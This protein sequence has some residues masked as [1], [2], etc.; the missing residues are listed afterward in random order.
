MNSDP[1]YNLDKLLEQL[2]NSNLSG[3]CIQ[4]GITKFDKIRRK[5]SRQII[6]AFCA[7]NLIVGA[8]P[9]GDMIGVPLI[10]RFMVQVLACFSSSSTR[11][12]AGFQAA[13]AAVLLLVGVGRIAGFVAALMTEFASLGIL[14][15]VGLAIGAAT[16]S[17]TTALIGELAYQYF[18]DP[19]DQVETKDIKW[20]TADEIDLLDCGFPLWQ[21]VFFWVFLFNDQT[22]LMYSTTLGQSWNRII[23][24]LKNG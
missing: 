16:G 3:S 9:V 21:F 24:N 11:T 10:T 22:I 15:P 12:V 7:A 2:N 14:L 6:A 23:L 1:V 18:V 19:E 8:I 17:A 13:H 5:I 20:V 4:T